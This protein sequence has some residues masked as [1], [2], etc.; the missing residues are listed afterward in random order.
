MVV[1]D[2][3][4]EVWRERLHKTKGFRLDKGDIMKFGRVRFRV[5]EISSELKRILELEKNEKLS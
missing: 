1:K 2:L 5:K 4:P 3:S